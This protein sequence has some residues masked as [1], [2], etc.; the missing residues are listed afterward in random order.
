MST[1]LPYTQNYLS[2][3]PGTDI[4]KKIEMSTVDNW[5]GLF[6]KKYGF[7]SVLLFLFFFRMSFI[8]CALW[9]KKK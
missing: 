8:K 3:M 6:D 9:G 2:I 7:V 5:N 4:G 1:V